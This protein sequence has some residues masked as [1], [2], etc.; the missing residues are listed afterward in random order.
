MGVLS[1]KKKV[2]FSN[3]GFTALLI[4]VLNVNIMIANNF[5]MFSFSQQQ[6]Y[7]PS[8]WTDVIPLLVL[9]RNEILEN[10]STCIEKLGKPLSA[11]AKIDE[12]TNSVLYDINVECLV[13]S[14]AVAKDYIV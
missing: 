11:K 8:Y 10:S 12:R 5:D 1:E 3:N 14:S 13:V 7:T 2:M 4:I 9:F 6:L